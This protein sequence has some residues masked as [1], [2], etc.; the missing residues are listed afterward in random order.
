MSVGSKTIVTAAPTGSAFRDSVSTRTVM[1]SW[2]P[3][4]TVPSK[5]W[6][7]PSPR[8]FTVELTSVPGVRLPDVNSSPCISSLRRNLRSATTA[9]TE[10]P[11]Q[12]SP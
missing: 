10:K 11:M 9:T 5:T 12:A 2:K 3:L 7:N 4:G 1:P 8:L 6:T